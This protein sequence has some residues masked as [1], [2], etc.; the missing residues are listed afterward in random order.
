MRGQF[1]CVAGGGRGAGAASPLREAP[2]RSVCT[3]GTNYNRWVYDQKPDWQKVQPRGACA[4][5]R[6]HSSIRAQVACGVIQAGRR[7]L[8]MQDTAKPATNDSS[9]HVTNPTDAVV[10]EVFFRTLKVTHGLGER[11][12]LPFRHALTQ[13]P[14]KLRRTLAV[15]GNQSPL[16]AVALRTLLGVGSDI[17]IESLRDDW[18]TGALIEY[19]ATADGEIACRLI[20]GN[21]DG[22]RTLSSSEFRNFAEYHPQ[23]SGV[24]RVVVSGPFP[25][26][27][28]GVV[29]IDTPPFDRTNEALASWP[30]SFNLGE[31]AALIRVGDDEQGEI[32]GVQGMLRHWEQICPVYRVQESSQP[33]MEELVSKMRLP[34]AFNPNELRTAMLR[35]LTDSAAPVLRRLA[36]EG[37]PDAAQH[38]QTIRREL[39]WYMREFRCAMEE[40]VLDQKRNLKN[41]LRLQLLAHPLTKTGLILSSRR[42]ALLG[43]YFASQLGPRLRL[44]LKRQ[45]ILL[46]RTLARLPRTDDDARGL[47]SAAQLWRVEVQKDVD[48]NIATTSVLIA[49]SPMMFAAATSTLAD[50]WDMG[51]LTM[52]PAM[53]LPQLATPSGLGKFASEHLGLDKLIGSVNQLNSTFQN[54]GNVLAQGF[55]V[56]LLQQVC[57]GIGQALVTIV[58][59]K[60]HFVLH[61]MEDE[62]D[63][64][65]EDLGQRLDQAIGEFEIRLLPPAKEKTER[66]DQAQ[67][68]VALLNEI[69]TWRSQA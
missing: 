45:A 58:R 51:R 37:R 61:E 11:D 44:L 6:Q 18:I 36:K 30:A 5:N 64:V 8:T 46:E 10:E 14:E 33:D 9:M 68:A 34:A 19:E 66:I 31:L 16:R 65:L 1:H 55:R 47:E 63:R 59:V 20:E 69:E 12:A 35:Y 52:P 32:K 24:Y 7:A 41:D 28:P 13:R 27:P 2:K 17:G 54:I 22:S 3:R 56:L 29:I 57:L 43:G 38:E 23:K 67:E 25:N 60:E 53:A 48:L 62:I 4:W 21:G 50:F 15:T 39:N 49:A 42:E 26:C 40:L